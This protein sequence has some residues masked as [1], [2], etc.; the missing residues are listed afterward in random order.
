MPIKFAFHVR[1][2]V[3]V[4][5]GVSSI[6]L[7]EFV[8]LYMF[9]RKMSKSKVIA[10]YVLGFLLAL[11][12]KYFFFCTRP[13]FD[14][15][16]TVSDAAWK[17]WSTGARSSPAWDNLRVMMHVIYCPSPSLLHSSPAF[18]FKPIKNFLTLAQNKIKLE[19]MKTKTQ[20]EQKR[21]IF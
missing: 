10:Y 6:W 2:I 11:L 12:Q 15:R 5:A 16:R 18:T 9:W 21:I 3:G 19:S 7:N 14:S 17:N 4:Y 8:T 13:I 20:K 1:S